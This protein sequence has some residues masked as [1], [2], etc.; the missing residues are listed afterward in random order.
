MGKNWWKMPLGFALMFVVLSGMLFLAL[1]EYAD[2]ALFRLEVQEA[3]GRGAELRGFLDYQAAQLDLLCIDWA[4][5]DQAYRFV[6]GGELSFE[7]ENL[8]LMSFENANLSHAAFFTK[9]LSVRWHGRYIRGTKWLAGCSGEEISLFK[10]LL[11]R[12][13]KTGYSRG[14]VSL[15]NQIYLMAARQIRDSDSKLPMAGWLVLT[16][17]LPEVKEMR[18]VVPGLIEI[19][20]IPRARERSPHRDPKDAVSIVPISSSSLDIAALLWDPLGNPVAEGHIR[21]DRWIAREVRELMGRVL[22]GVALLGLG[23]CTGL[24]MWHRTHISE[25]LQGVYEKVAQMTASGNLEMLSLESGE[26]EGIVKAMNSLI[27]HAKGVERRAA[28]EAGRTRDIL[29]GMDLMVALCSPDGTI[30]FAN[31]A[32]ASLFRDLPSLTGTRFW[33]LMDHQ[34]RERV[35]EQFLAAG[36]G[37]RPL[38]RVHLRSR[39]TSLV[40]NMSPIKSPKAKG[41]VMVLCRATTASLPPGVFA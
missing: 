20:P 38:L 5:W 19:S 30:S 25:P 13:Y 9:G 1:M 18:G 28:M 15:D 26:L 27:S 24:I 29:D 23:M 12:S 14:I 33:D 4:N 37:K 36:E 35:R 34:D 8:N 10:E 41:E 7:E 32:M 16:R 17:P 40:I 2:R 22:L 39:R 21:V 6:L 11:A 31:R 3:R